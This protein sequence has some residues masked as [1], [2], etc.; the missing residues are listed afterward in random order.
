MTNFAAFKPGQYNKIPHHNTMYNLEN[1][2]GIEY[3]LYI[4]ILAKNYK[5]L[6]LYVKITYNQ[7]QIIQS[8]LIGDFSHFAY[9]D[10]SRI[11]S[12]PGVQDFLMS[13]HCKSRN[14]KD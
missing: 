8:H 7:F 5:F 6:F 2:I 11:F 13:C 1:I 12:V 3:T 4:Q 9:H 10:C 14:R